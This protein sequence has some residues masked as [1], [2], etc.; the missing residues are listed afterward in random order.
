MRAAQ[1]AAPALRPERAKRYAKPVRSVTLLPPA[2]SAFCLRRAVDL[3]GVALMLVALAMT[4]CFVSYNHD[5]PSFNHATN[6]HAGNLLGITGSYTADLFITSLGYASA[7]LPLAIGVWGLFILQRRILA[8]WWLR[9]IGLL[10]CLIS[11]SILLSFLSHVGLPMA[12]GTAGYMAH[13]FLQ[14]ILA[15]LTGKF[16]PAL[17]AGTSLFFSPILLVAALG[18]TLGE[19][20]AGFSRSARLSRDAAGHATGLAVAVG[21]QTRDLANWRPRAAPEQED[22]PPEIALLDESEVASASPKPTRKKACNLAQ[23][24]ANGTAG[25]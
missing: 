14:K 10:L 13:G 19:W 18:F 3:G 25:G 9:V 21:T 20:H 7:I 1:T 16:T 4:L 5:D 22:A 12:G 8:R 17:I 15:P 6:A 24:C 2:L 23:G 11:I